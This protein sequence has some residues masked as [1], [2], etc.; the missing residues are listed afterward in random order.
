MTAGGTGAVEIRPVRPEEYEEAG[1][2]TADAYREFAG[3]DA[4][5]QEY[6]V[7]LADV[8]DRVRRTIVLVAVDDGRVLGTVTL[9]LED[10]TDAGRQD[11]EGRPLAPGEAHVRMLGVAPEARGRGIGRLLMEACL[12]E[13][14]RAGKTLITLDTTERMRVAQAM[15]R[16]MGFTREEDTVFPDGFVLMS[17]SLPLGPP[18]GAAV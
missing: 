16:S 15:Y 9:E 11:A 18:S 3:P 1:R 4:A 2:V 5:W 14:R 7:R 13:A 10:R 17:Y 12:E 6:L 8:A